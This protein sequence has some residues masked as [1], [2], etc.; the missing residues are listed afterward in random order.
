M[1]FVNYARRE[2]SFKIVY[3]GPSLGGKTT[4]LRQVHARLAQNRTGRLVTI[5]TENDRTLF[6]D[7]LP[8]ELGAIGGFT[9]RFQIYSVP[10]QTFYRASRRL[11]LSGADGV[12]FVVD[13]QAERKAENVESLKNLY[14]NLKLYGR[15]LADI[16]LVFQY[17]KRDLPSAMKIAELEATFNP[18]Q[19]PSFETIASTG[20]GI[21]E[22]L[23]AICKMVIEDWKK[24]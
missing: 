18:R 12:V 22:P 6:F 5:A 23:R 2:I 3:Y 4:L 24:P 20:G 21:F 7:F 10:G 9:V 13:S 19:R 1:P 16:P 8:V 14:D 17:N 15:R 11:M